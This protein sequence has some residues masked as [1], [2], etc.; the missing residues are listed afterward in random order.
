[1]KI[2][3]HDNPLLPLPTL[4][5]AR[6]TQSSHTI[7]SAPAHYDD[8]RVYIHRPASFKSYF[9]TDANAEPGGNWKFTIEAG[10]LPDIG[11]ATYEIFGLIACGKEP[12]QEFLASGKINVV[13][14]AMSGTP[15]K[16]LGVP[17]RVVIYDETGAAHYLT[18]VPDG[19]GNF[20]SIVE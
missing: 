9:T 7:T 14:R 6:Y 8:I 11:E 17:N 5:L 19:M 12:E 10:M 1:M 20:T 15:A 2:R 18:A 16:P 4:E 13:E 3:I